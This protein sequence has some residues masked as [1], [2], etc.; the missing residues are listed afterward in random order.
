MNRCR[1]FVPCLWILGLL[2]SAPAASAQ[3]GFATTLTEAEVEPA[4]SGSLATG[5]AWFSLDPA[6]DMLFY[7]VESSVALPLSAEIYVGPLGAVGVPV[8]PLVFVGPS[9]WQGATPALGVALRTELFNSNFYV[10]IES[11]A[12]PGGDI[13]GQINK[14]RMRTQTGTLTG[15]EAATPSP[16]I[17][18]AGT[19]TLLPERRVLYR[20]TA[21]GLLA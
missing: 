6:T 2:A 10:Q 8:F 12:F 3:W 7:R 21:V 4:A 11:V 19:V 5:R 20:M 18:T 16:A 14:T 9:T 15:L 17:G 1:R 13:R